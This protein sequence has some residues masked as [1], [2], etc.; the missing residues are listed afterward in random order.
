MPDARESIRLG[1]WV[2][3]FLYKEPCKIH[4]TTAMSWRP[5][6][7]GCWF[8]AVLDEEPCEMFI[9]LERCLMQRSPSIFILG[10]WVRALLD[11]EPWEIHM[12]MS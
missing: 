8:G 9:I 6:N 5:L 1:C 10:C 12:A 4:M 3:A 11:E 7:S 2:C